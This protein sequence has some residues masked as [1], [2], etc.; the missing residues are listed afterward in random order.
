MDAPAPPAR[1]SP[2]GRERMNGWERRSY[3]MMRPIAACIADRRAGR[4]D[5]IEWRRPAGPPPAIDSIPVP[6]SAIISALLAPRSKH[7]EGTDGH[8]VCGCRLA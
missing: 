5:L 4:S 7:R 1:R 6:A 2:P 8:D 3:P